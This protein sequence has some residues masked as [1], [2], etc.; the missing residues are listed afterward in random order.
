MSATA[1]ARAARGPQRTTDNR[2]TPA[3]AVRG[4]LARLGRPARKALGQ[5]FLID[6]AAAGRIVALAGIAP[7]GER[8]VE[9]GPGLG[10]LTARLAATAGS[11]WLVEIDSDLAERLRTTYAGEPK[12]HVVQADI[13]EVDLASLLGLGPR[14]VVVAN[15]PYNIATA[16]LMK[17]LAQP[18]CFRRLVVMIQR[19]VAERLRAA[20]GSKTYGA[21]SV[22]TQA[23]A[24]VRRGF[25]VGP[26]AFVPR[27][28]VDS[29]VVCIEPYATPPVP[30]ADPGRFRQVVLAA[31]NQ[32]RK[33]L[34]N[35]LAGVLSEAP[36]ALRDLG[37][38]PARRAETLSLAEFAAV[39]A[40]ARH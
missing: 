36:A 6:A 17:L 26:D 40:A 25:R 19:E 39:A 27:P 18:A 14:A 10:A 3:A 38:D 24:E 8:V 9:I 21:L 12:V 5:H 23:A 28:K 15:L 37:I 1:R 29:E 33:Q 32:R 4:E 35:S 22:F 34:G 31:F 2:S 11:L 16:V 30:I 13:L 20:P 7:A